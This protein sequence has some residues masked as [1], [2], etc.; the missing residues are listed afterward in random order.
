M[1]HYRTYCR[2]E[3]S[4]WVVFIHGAG[5]SSAVWYKQ[6]Q[7]YAR[8]F[9]L[10]LIDLRGHGNS[11]DGPTLNRFDYSFE[12]IALDV[13]E[14]LDHLE[15]K[16]AHFVG[17]SLGTIVIR[18]FAEMRSKYVKSM[19]MVGA[20]TEMNLKSRFLVRI[21]N[22]FRHIMPPMWLYRLF[23]FI[24]MPLG[25]ASE[26]RNVFIREAQKLAKQE[27]IRWFRLTNRLTTK[28]RLMEANDTGI[29]ILYVMGEYD[30]LF[31]EP[32]RQRVKEFAHQSLAVVEKC[33]HVVN[34]EKAGQFN[35]LSI[36]FIRQLQM[37]NSGSTPE[38][39]LAS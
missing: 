8:H 12:S 34:I 21:G 3:A 2:E 15:I 22:M 25:Q 24:I 31:L 37:D 13:A 36:A 18:K 32:I 19:I 39:S 28:L 11:A 23:A 33:G 7:A 4:D 16:Q 17:V 9:N 10:L 5:G 1:L 20:I 26:S 6:I 27:F 38:K 14:V 35:D 29:P 30:H